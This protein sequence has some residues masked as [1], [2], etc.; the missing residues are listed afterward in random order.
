MSPNGCMVSSDSWLIVTGAF[1]K[2]K[3]LAGAR[4]LPGQSSD[5]E[6]LERRQMWD[7]QL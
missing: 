7:W 4:H 2:A 1:G 6:R 5:P 3:L